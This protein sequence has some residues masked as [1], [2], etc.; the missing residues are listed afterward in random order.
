[1]PAEPT[2][3]SGDGSSRAG[4]SGRSGDRSG[5][6]TACRR[7]VEAIRNWPMLLGLFL[8]AGANL[9]VI[10]MLQRGNWSSWTTGG[11]LAGAAAFQAAIWLFTTR[12][13]AATR[14]GDADDIPRL[15]RETTYAVP[16]TFASLALLGVLAL[17]GYFVL[18]FAATVFPPSA[19]VLLVVALTLG[20]AL[21]LL[22]V[23]PAIAI[24]AKGPATSI[25]NSVL[26]TSGHRVDVIGIVVVLGVPNSLLTRHLQDVHGI[27][28]AAVAG[29][30][31]VLTGA[32]MLVIA[33]LY[34]ADYG[35]W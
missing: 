23:I 30:V 27:R 31:G 22:F 7:T 6:W 2:D 32:T 35:G 10:R 28:F 24:G 29:V 3:V 4:G 14:E 1:M 15:V 8:L 19:V 17:V 26:F 13:A 16:V 11:V 33:F 9:G 34:H 25:G 12:F 20:L 5:A 21:H 18:A